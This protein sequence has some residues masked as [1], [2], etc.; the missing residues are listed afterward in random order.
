MG[1]YP[2]DKIYVFMMNFFTAVQF[3]S[4]RAYYKR[5]RLLTAPMLSDFM[6]IGGYLTL[7]FGP[8]L[9]LFDHYPHDKGEDAD[10]R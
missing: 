6:L 1:F 7:I 2:N 3:F 5:I 4:Y 10:F 8:L 9:A